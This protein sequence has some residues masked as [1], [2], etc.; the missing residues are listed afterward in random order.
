[1]KAFTAYRGTFSLSQ[2]SNYELAQSMPC[3]EEEDKVKTKEEI[4]LCFVRL[5]MWL[6][7]M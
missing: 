5:F 1:M 7:M 2:I 3:K 6:P 4:Q